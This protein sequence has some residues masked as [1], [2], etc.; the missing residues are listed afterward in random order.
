MRTPEINGG[1]FTN[2]P[3][4]EV[5]SG[6]TV[7]TAEQIINPANFMTALRAGSALPIGYM[8]AKGHEFTGLAMTASAFLDKEGSV[9]RWGVEHGKNWV[10]EIGRKADPIADK[11]LAVGVAAGTVAYEV[12]HGNPGLTIAILSEQVAIAGLS[13]YSEKQNPGKLE[14]GMIGKVGISFVFG[15]LAAKNLVH[16]DPIAHNETAREI[17]NNGANV[18]GVSALGLVGAA[19]RG[20]W[21]K[22]KNFRKNKQQSE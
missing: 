17:M 1:D 2:T 10:T 16:F 19:M 9:A 18:I 21:R 14:V 11:L 7:E 12:G 8:A 3:V 4:N 5:T 13:I 6:Q 22:I 15:Y 20:Y